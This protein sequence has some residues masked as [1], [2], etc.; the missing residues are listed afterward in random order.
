MLIKGFHVS[1]VC[2]KIIFFLSLFV[3]GMLILSLSPRIFQNVIKIEIKK[4]V[5]NK[6]EIIF[7][8]K[9]LDEECTNRRKFGKLRFS[10]ALG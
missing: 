9:T 2:N 10:F 4:S 5:L 3:L 7:K 6:S 8:T 1:E